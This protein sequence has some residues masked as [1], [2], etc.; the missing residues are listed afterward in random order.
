[1]LVTGSKYFF[2]HAVEVT[3]YKKIYSSMFNSKNKIHT[4][5][6]QMTTEL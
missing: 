6:E 4:S 5:S 2:S 3:G 1:M